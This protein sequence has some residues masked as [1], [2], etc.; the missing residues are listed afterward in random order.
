[1]PRQRRDARAQD[2]ERLSGRELPYRDLLEPS[3]QRRVPENPALVLLVRRGTEHPE[4]ATG[5]RGLE[6]VRRVHR[7][8][9][10]TALPDQVVH[11]VDEQQYV[12]R[13]TCFG[14]Q[15]AQPLLV[16]AA[17]RRPCQ[18]ADGVQR[19]QTQIAQRDRHAPLR[20]AHGEPLRDGGLADPGLANERGIVLSLAEQDVDGAGDLLVATPNDLESAG[21]CVVSEISRE[22]I[23][24]G[25]FGRVMLVHLLLCEGKEFRCV[26]GVEESTLSVREA[27]QPA[28]E[29]PSSI[30]WPAFTHGSTEVGHTR[31]VVRPSSK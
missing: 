2:L 15:R 29:G 27:F 14:D 25:R 19:Q 8:T 31:L 30:P 17:I 28:P 24:G 11:L 22:T 12:A 26:A 21:A 3:L 23:Q 13:G 10:R 16:L 1:M 6:H 20:N 5:E 4:L 9:T 18:Q 7:R